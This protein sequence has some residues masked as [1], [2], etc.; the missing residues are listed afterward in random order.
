MFLPNLPL[1]PSWN[2]VRDSNHSVTYFGKLVTN[3]VCISCFRLEIR[4]KRW[5]AQGREELRSRWTTRRTRTHRT[6]PQ[7]WVTCSPDFQ[8]WRVPNASPTPSGRSSSITPVSLRIFFGPRRSPLR[9]NLRVYGGSLRSLTKLRSPARS[10]VTV[11]NKRGC[12]HAPNNVWRDVGLRMI[13]W[14]K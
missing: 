1:F 10:A 13:V 12:R 4:L 9:E 11:I 5:R 2:F 8:L 7:L 14:R 3:W 6:L